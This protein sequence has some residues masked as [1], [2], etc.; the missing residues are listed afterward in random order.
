MAERAEGPGTKALAGA[1]VGGLLGYALLG[2]FAAEKA[3]SKDRQTAKALL[4]HLNGFTPHRAFAEAFAQA[5]QDSGRSFEVMVLE[6]DPGASDVYDAVAEF[7]IEEWGI[8]LACR[9]S[10]N[11]VYDPCHKLPSDRI[12]PKG[13]P[14]IWQIVNR[15]RP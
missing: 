14:L 3:E 15:I 7:R 2:G 11:F 13:L 4:E 10:P 5:L 8:R 9:R 6:R 12:A 1:A